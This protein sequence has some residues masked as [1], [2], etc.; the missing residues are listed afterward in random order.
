MKQNREHDAVI[1][2]MAEVNSG[3]WSARRFAEE[4]CSQHRTLQQ[5]LMKTFVTTIR[6][7]AS[8]RYGYDD[9]NRASHHAAVRMVESGIL[10]EICLPMI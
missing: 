2:L 7:M 1:N 3:T 8:D 10:D 6:E 4:V 5:L 9:R